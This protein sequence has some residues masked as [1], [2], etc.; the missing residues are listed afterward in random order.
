M[1]VVTVLLAASTK[2]WMVYLSLKVVPTHAVVATH[3]LSACKTLGPLTDRS[4]MRIGQILVALFVKLTRQVML[5]LY[6]MQA[7]IFLVT[8]LDAR[9]LLLR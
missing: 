5:F 6:A 3:L 2:K 1:V 9:V 7:V 8:P 4:Q